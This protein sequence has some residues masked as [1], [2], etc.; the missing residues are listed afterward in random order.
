VASPE[1]SGSEDGVGSG[2]SAKGG[3]TP[4]S[5]SPGRVGEE[6]GRE[7]EEAGQIAPAAAAAAEA[8]RALGGLEEAKE[9]Q[10]EKLRIKMFVCNAESGG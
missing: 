1:S 5:D 4:E 10:Q 7:G 8:A 6:G 3:T 2:G 9:Q